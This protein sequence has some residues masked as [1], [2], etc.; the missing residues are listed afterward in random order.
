MELFF[1]LILVAVVCSSRM[2]L[3]SGEEANIEVHP[4]AQGGSVRLQHADARYLWVCTP[5]ELRCDSEEVARS[6][7]E[8]TRRVRGF[9]EADGRYPKIMEEQRQDDWRHSLDEALEKMSTTQIENNR[10]LWKSM[11]KLQG[12]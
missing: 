12:E 10:E 7:E 2:M 3:V 8:S 6:T 4:N 1:L 9:A 11:R 5:R